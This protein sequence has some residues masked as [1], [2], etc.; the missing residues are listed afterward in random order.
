MLLLSDV[1]EK[2]HQFKEAALA[3]NRDY[4]DILQQISVVKLIE[5]EPEKIV[6]AAKNKEIPFAGKNGALSFLL[7]KK[8]LLELQ[9]LFYDF[10]E[11]IEPMDLLPLLERDEYRYVMTS[12]RENR[13]DLKSACRIGNIIFATVVSKVVIDDT[14][15]NLMLYRIKKKWQKKFIKRVI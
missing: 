7:V 3:L 1:Q 9:N 6:N 8:K 13:Q 15:W 2:A 11:F 12:A 10:S 4:K 14:R 5:L